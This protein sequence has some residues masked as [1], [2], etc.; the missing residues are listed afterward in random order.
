MT[1]NV[2]DST[3]TEASKDN[4]SAIDPFWDNQDDLLGLLLSINKKLDST[5]TFQMGLLFLVYLG[6]AVGGVY[7]NLGADYGYSLAEYDSWVTYAAGFVVWFFVSNFISGIQEKLVYI[8]NVG[9]IKSALSQRAISRNILISKI[10]KSPG[11]KL[12]KIA[13]RLEMDTF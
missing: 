6:L 11:L 1:E 4:E 3:G 8:W 12:N 13:E 9:T 5:G 7:F 10:E 2:E